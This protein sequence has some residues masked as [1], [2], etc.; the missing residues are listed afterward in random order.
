MRNR[1]DLFVRSELA[2]RIPHSRGPDSWGGEELPYKPD[3]VPPAEAG[4]RPFLWEPCRHGPQ[5]PYPEVITARTAP[6]LPTWAFSRWGLPCH[7]CH[8]ARGALLPHPFTLTGDR[9][10]LGG[11]LSAAL[12]LGLP[13]VVVNHHRVLWSPDF[14]RR[15]L[16]P[17]AA[18]RAT[19][20]EHSSDARLR[21]GVV[22]SSASA[23]SHAESR[24]LRSSRGKPWLSSSN[25]PPGATSPLL[26]WWC[27][28]RRSLRFSCL[29]VAWAARPK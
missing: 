17:A 28:A 15:G 29:P 7:A 20:P 11:L 19:L 16:G 24:S 18:A 13:P 10:R 23:D 14:P 2:S 26:P 8:Q 5:T 4:R 25:N 6:F 21:R 27:G 9:S 12:S 22:R 3:L 1:P